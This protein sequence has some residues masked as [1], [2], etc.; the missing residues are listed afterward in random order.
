MIWF[1]IIIKLEINTFLRSILQSTLCLVLD[2]FFDIPT[3]GLQT[4][5]HLLRNNYSVNN[6]EL[7]FQ[8]YLHQ[9]EQLYS[10]GLNSSTLSFPRLFSLITIL[11]YFKLYASN[12]LG[13]VLFHLGYLIWVFISLMKMDS[14]DIIMLHMHRI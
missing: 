7:F 9:S 5:G 10:V 11:F 13:N 14:S 2:V 4:Q 6:N 1:D 8:S 12:N 3:I